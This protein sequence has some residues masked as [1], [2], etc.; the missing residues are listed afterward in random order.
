MRVLEKNEYQLVIAALLICVRT[1]TGLVWG[2][3][4]PLMPLMMQDYGIGRGTVSWYASVVAI[5]IGIFSVPVGILGMRMRTKWLFAIG[6]LLLSSCIFSPFCPS[7]AALLAT[8]VAFAV[9]VG[10]TTPTA[11]A[12]AAQWFT[13]RQLPVVN[14]LTL[15]FNTIGNATAYLITIPLATAFSWRVALVFYGAIALIFALA[16]SFWGRERRQSVD[17]SVGEKK[18]PMDIKGA[19]KQRTTLLLAIGLIGP[20]CLSTAISS[21]LP[22]YYHEV[23]GMTLQRGSSITAVSTVT[24][25]IACLAGGILPMRI[26]LRRP[27]LLI[28]GLLMG[29]AA[30]GCFM[31]NNPAVIFTSLLLFGIFSSIYVASIFTIPMELSGINP[32]TGAIVL[33]LALSVGNVG[34]FIGPT[35]VGYLADLTGSYLP[36]FIGC[37]VL[38]LS[39]L[40]CG[41]LLPET[42]PGARRVASRVP[43]AVHD[44][45]DEDISKI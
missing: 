13:A 38:S 4:G 30:L 16:W 27:F 20:F 1:C 8:R 45:E 41:L 15:G 43:T 18:I 25:V 32:R 26:G 28:P 34:S 37:C 6:A 44:P 19:L 31:V 39:L 5:I 3:G 29:P 14:G 21:W 10:I 33:A 7:F 35:I 24:G 12:I 22:T 42:G 23:F 40:F 17:D 2:S 11:A 9:G 36:G